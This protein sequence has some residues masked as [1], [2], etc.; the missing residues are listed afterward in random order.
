MGNPGPTQTGQRMWNKARRRTPRFRSVGGHIELEAETGRRLWLTVVPRG[1]GA[2]P[3]SLTDI[4]LRLRP[5][6]DQTEA[7]RG[8]QGVSHRGSDGM[9]VHC[10]DRDGGR[11][12]ML[13]YLI[14]C[15]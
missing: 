8:M 5:D 15:P 3:G 12:G 4:R 11:A 1:D 9:V 13:E 2:V 14:F 10:A 7:G 6:T